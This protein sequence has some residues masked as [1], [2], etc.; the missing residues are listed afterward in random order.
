MLRERLSGRDGIGSPYGTPKSRYNLYNQEEQPVINEQ[1]L[2]LL[3]L[4]LS[5]VVISGKI[6]TNYRETIS[7]V[8][9]EHK[10]VSY[11]ILSDDG[12]EMLVHSWKTVLKYSNIWLPLL[13]GFLS[14]YFTW[15][16]VYLD[17][18]VP[19]VQPPSPLSPRRYKDQSGHTFHLNYVFA[20]VVGI[21]VFFYMYM[22][23]VSIEYEG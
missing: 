15:M 13:F 23:G 22:K 6:I 16:M 4:L 5:A 8:L 19:G 14:S 3:G 10:L 1:K 21:L 12:N 9:L 11:E 17:S 20:I 7:K 2:A 18:A